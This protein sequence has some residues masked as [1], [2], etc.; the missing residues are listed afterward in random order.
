MRL[1]VNELRFAKNP[2][3][4]LCGKLAH[5]LTLVLQM[6]WC[7][8]SA[9]ASL[10]TGLSGM[11]IPVSQRGAETQGISFAF[12]S[13]WMTQRNHTLARLATWNFPLCAL[14]T[15]PWYKSCI[16]GMARVCNTLLHWHSSEQIPC[17]LSLCQAPVI[18]KWAIPTQG[19]ALP[20][21]AC[22]T[23]TSAAQ[24]RL[25]II[26]LCL[27]LSVLMNSPVVC[28]RNTHSFAYLNVKSIFP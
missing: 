8:S 25:R 5:V 7:L 4:L 20:T 16:W 2:L 23:K 13:S 1:S 15:C 27:C 10:G 26:L 12:I 21:A 22:Q 11:V 14:C 18:L 9:S 19:R 6:H 3:F 17:W 24:H 28:P